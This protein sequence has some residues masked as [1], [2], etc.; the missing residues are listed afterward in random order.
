MHGGQ[1]GLLTGPQV[2]PVEA[3]ARL[4]LAL[5]VVVGGRHH[6][7][8]PA[9][10]RERHVQPAACELAQVVAV[11]DVLAVHLAGVDEGGVLVQLLPRAWRE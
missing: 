6:D 1:G 8:A 9:V 10:G 4:C 7:L 3:P 11:A 2:A 5:F